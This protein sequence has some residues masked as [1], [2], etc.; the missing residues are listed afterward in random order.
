MNW[1]HE[2]EKLSRNIRQGK[3]KTRQVRHT[4][5]KEAENTNLNPCPTASRGHI[6]MPLEKRIPCQYFENFM[7]APTAKLKS[8]NQLKRWQ[9]NFF[10]K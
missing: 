7:L 4:T 8:K 5:L 10:Q 1:A 3:K 2:K 6:Y 9:S